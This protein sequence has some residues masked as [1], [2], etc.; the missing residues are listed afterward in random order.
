[1]KWLA[2]ILA[3]CMTLPAH[4]ADVRQYITITPFGRTLV[5]DL[6]AATARNTLGATAGAWS[7]AAVA[8][9]IT[10]A[11]SPS[12]GITPA[13]N[14]TGL[15]MNTGSLTGA[16]QNPFVDFAGTWNTTGTP[17]AWKLNITDT[18]SNAASLLADIQ[19]GGASRFNVGK[20]GGTTITPGA[21]AG[22]D[23]LKFDLNA[24]DTI[25]IIWSMSARTFP[26]VNLPHSVTPNNVTN[27]G[28]NVGDNG[29]PRDSSKATL[30]TAMEANYYLSAAGPS[31]EHHISSFYPAG[32]GAEKRPLS[33][34]MRH[35]GT[36]GTGAQGQIQIGQFNF[37][38]WTNVAQI[39]LDLD[40]S[41][42]YLAD[43]FKWQASYNNAPFMQQLNAAGNGTVRLPYVNA[44]NSITVESGANFVGAVPAAG[45]Y[46]GEFVVMQ[47]TTAATGNTLL[48]MYNNTV[49]GSL[50]AAQLA[51]DVTQEYN[52]A[53][54]NNNNTTTANVVQELRTIGATGGDPYTR[55]SINGVTQ[56]SV[57]IDNSD[58]DKF[59]VSSSTVLGTNDRFTVDTSGN[60]SV[61]GTLGLGNGTTTVPA[62]NLGDAATGFWRNA[63]NQW[64][65]TIGGSNE[66]SFIASVLRLK[67]SE[68]LVWSATADSTAA[69]DVGFS[70]LAAGSLELNDGQTNGNTRD[71]SLRN[72][73]AT[74]LNNADFRA[75]SDFW[76]FK[77]LAGSSTLVSFG[78]G[79]MNINSNSALYGAG[80]TTDTWWERPAAGIWSPIGASTT[81]GTVRYRANSATQ[82]TANQNDY[83]PGGVSYFQRWSS[84]ASRNV[85][86]LTFTPAKQDGQ[87]HLI[88]NVG[89]QNIVLAHESASSAAANRFKNSTAADITLAANQAADVI[90]DGTQSRWLVF[91]RN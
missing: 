35:D 33:F 36:G 89:A 50:F 43:S 69:A 79:F 20:N 8:D 88:V 46:P 52:F 61:A 22:L 91:K 37:L 12:V 85:T 42:G 59:K 49:T 56:W 11:G 90:Y 68:R 45:N 83:N 41:I 55:Y 15:T 81:G 54:Y 34:V 44:G 6:D 3:I 62:I 65:W 9:N 31:F 64:T 25:D 48:R 58:S 2:F 23:L 28:I 84:D 57:G 82:I 39:Q 53:I 73:T 7:D 63:V 47:T 10:I 75:P 86:G 4:A 66:I 76:A 77:N 80:A 74:T 24:L 1:M 67:S 70:R 51:G 18:A 60:A 17:T 13:A 5:D 19:V 26:N 29:A 32:G 14:T 27:W 72:L 38:D 21:V 71:L 87:T 40:N 16:N 30:R 78:S